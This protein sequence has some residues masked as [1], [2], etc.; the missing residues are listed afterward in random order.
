MKPSKT[1]LTAGLVGI[2]G[3]AATNTH[4]GMATVTAPTVTSTL[5]KQAALIDELNKTTEALNSLCNKPATADDL[6]AGENSIVDAAMNGEK[7]FLFP[8]KGY[9]YP[10]YMPEPRF[11]ESMPMQVQVKY[12]INGKDDTVVVKDL[13]RPA[14]ISD[15]DFKVEILQNTKWQAIDNVHWH[16]GHFLAQQGNKPVWQALDTGLIRIKMIE[17]TIR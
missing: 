2:L 8:M 12:L 16:N 1:Y 14:T 13:V 7:Q 10:V 17:G 3:L 6:L 9:L 5:E 11:L 4:A 15:N